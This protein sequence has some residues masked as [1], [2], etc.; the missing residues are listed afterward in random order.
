MRMTGVS[1]DADASAEPCDV[2][3]DPP[4]HVGGSVLDMIPGLTNATGSD[5]L[6]TALEARVRRA[7]DANARPNVQRMVR[8][9]GR[10]SG[11]AILTLFAFGTVM[12]ATTLRYSA[13][14]RSA[15]RL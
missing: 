7:I 13:M 15:S 11:A 4:P 9:A 6:A 5:R 8:V 3:C 12:T 14:R 10:V 1:N 2:G